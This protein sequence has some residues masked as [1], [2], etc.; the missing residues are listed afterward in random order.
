[1]MWNGIHTGLRLG[2]LG[3]LTAAS[4]QDARKGAI[5][6]RIFQGFALYG[7][8]CQSLMLGV[9]IWE[10]GGVA[11]E[12]L[13]SA[14]SLAGAAGIGVA[15][16]VLSDVTEEGIGKGDGWFFLVSGLYLGLWKNAVF[17]MG[18]LL[19]SLPFC[20]VLFLRCIS[21]GRSARGVRLPFLPFTVPAGI[22]VL[23]L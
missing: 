15:L 20:M 8:I 12:Q 1:M 9:G 4:W 10:Q 14:G 6:L 18:S 13:R 23:F 5:D 2:F 7:V 22:G 17:F 19:V 11:M 21:E 16:L 3:F